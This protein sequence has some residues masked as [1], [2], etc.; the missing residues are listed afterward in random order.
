MATPPAR[1]ANTRGAAHEP[2]ARPTSRV[3]GRICATGRRRATGPARRAAIAASLLGLLAHASVAEA[4]RPIT[5]EADA[6]TL[7][8]DWAAVAAAEHAVPERLMRAIARA[9]TGRERLGTVRAWP[10]AVNVEGEGHW[11]DSRQEA[12][13]YAGARLAA[14]AAQ[15]DIGCFQLN[16]GWH[17]RAFAGLDQMIDPA[18]NARYA[19]RFLAALHDEF[20]DW[21]RAAAAYHSRTPEHGRAYVARLAAIVETI[22]ERARDSDG[23]GLAALLPLATPSVGTA[24]A[25]PLAATQPPRLGSLVP[26]G[27]PS[28]TPTAALGATR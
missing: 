6:A 25:R 9:E 11:F 26:L 15:V 24:T 2:G 7:C 23:K 3:D 14:G 21:T 19:A 1:P 20:G 18:R 13:D 22:P 12:L 16:V 8:E 5:A 28:A 10:W 17:A 27:G 4:V